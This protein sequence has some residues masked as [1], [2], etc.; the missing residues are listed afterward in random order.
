MG[1]P[2]AHAYK[3]SPAAIFYYIEKD[4][5]PQVHNVNEA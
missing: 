4:S 5:V 2:T 3:K 1:N